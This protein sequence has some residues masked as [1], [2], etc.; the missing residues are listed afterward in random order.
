MPKFCLVLVL[1]A[2]LLSCDDRRDIRDYYFPVRELIN[3]EGKV[4]AYASTGSL[5][6]PDTVYYYYLGVDVDTA[7]HLTS[8]RYGPDLSP[9]QLS[10]QEVTND[11]VR[12]RE[13]IVFNPD[14]AGVAVPTRAEVLFD[15]AFP[16]YLAEPPSPHGYRIRLGEGPGRQTFVTLNRDFRGDT[17]VRIQGRAYDAITFDLRGEVSQRDAERGDISPTFTGYEIY[18]RG[19]GLVEYYRNLGAA[20]TLGGR[21]V[22]ALPMSE[23]AGSSSG[24]MR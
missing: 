6:G 7:L 13:L 9:Q 15:R 16:F 20:G 12:M 19:L 10:R 24:P 11:G 5:P 1:L 2:T 8:T 3:T 23:F 22:R 4:Y 17:T 14:T 21:Y 18:A